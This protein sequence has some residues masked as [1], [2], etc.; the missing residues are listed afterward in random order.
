MADEKDFIAKDVT[1]VSCFLLFTTFLWRAL[2]LAFRLLGD[3][4]H[5]LVL[6]NGIMCYDGYVQIALLRF[7]TESRDMRDPRKVFEEI[8]DRDLV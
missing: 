8:T 6:K 2:K 3:Q 7:Y 5:N 4:I 1:E